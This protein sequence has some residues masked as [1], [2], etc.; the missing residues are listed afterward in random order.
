[1]KKYITPALVLWFLAPVFGELF[2]GS[3][4]LNEYL[5]PFTIL[6]FGM[7][8]GSGAILIR[9]LIVRWKKGWPS[10]LLLGL[11]YGIFEEGLL[12]RSFFDPGWMDLGKLS[13]YGRAGEV[14]WLWAEHL[15]IYHAL[16]SIAASIVFVEILFPARRGEPWLGPRGLTWNALFFAASLPIGALLNPYEAPD[17]LLGMCWLAIAALTLA[18]WRIPAPAP[19]STSARAGSPWFFFGFSFLAT[20]GQF[21]IV[22]LTGEK[23]SPS[24]VVTMFLLAAYDLCLLWILRRRSGNFTAWDDRHRIALINGALTFFLL[25][26]PLTTGG[27]YPIMTVSNPIFFFLLLWTAHQVDRR[28]TAERAA[29]T[30]NVPPVNPS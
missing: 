1:M 22:Y 26:G 30:T 2:S 8:Y 11:A 17:F 12:V 20:F 9:E 18:A 7:L 4:P 5:N 24:F 14:N 19:A 16:I 28:V 6:V 29:Q 23:E 15:T 25:I 27:Q 10:L 3:T 21:F 13:I